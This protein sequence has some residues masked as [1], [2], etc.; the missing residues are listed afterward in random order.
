MPTEGQ[1]KSEL[2]DEIDSNVERSGL[3]KTVNE[4][5]PTRYR[6]G[7]DNLKKFLSEFD[8]TYMDRSK[9]K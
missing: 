9:P 8:Y 4:L 2:Q 3:L 7:N 1:P 6:F 5:N